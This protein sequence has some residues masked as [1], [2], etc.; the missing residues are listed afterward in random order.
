[1]A[2]GCMHVYRRDPGRSEGGIHLQHTEWKAGKQHP[3]EMGGVEAFPEA[4]KKKKE[5]L[6]SLQA[7]LK[8]CLACFRMGKE[9]GKKASLFLSRFLASKQAS[10]NQAVVVKAPLLL[11]LAAAA[12]YEACCVL[13]FIAACLPVYGRR[14]V[15]KRGNKQLSEMDG[16]MEKCREG[17]V[18]AR[19]HANTF[20]GLELDQPVSIF[21]CS[22]LSRFQG[23][24]R[25]FV[26]Q[27]EREY[28]F[29]PVGK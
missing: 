14:G 22:P 29:A 3:M 25:F 15:T 24:A 23:Q 7:Q 26:Q 27:R 12:S 1:M 21:S 18:R 8:P 2:F 10:S 28:E 5:S 4:R 20:Y 16:P 13:M 19:F 6:A 17:G 9:R 11:L